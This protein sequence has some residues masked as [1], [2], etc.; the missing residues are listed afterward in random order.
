MQWS[1][2]PFL[3]LANV[4]REDVCDMTLDKETAA[5]F[6]LAVDRQVLNCFLT[7]TKL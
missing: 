1:D 7:L 5:E 4:D 6:E 3:F 2:L